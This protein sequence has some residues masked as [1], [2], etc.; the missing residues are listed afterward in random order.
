MR[1]GSDYEGVSQV[2]KARS[3]MR[4]ASKGALIGGITLAMIATS[5]TLLF[6]I[7]SASTGPCGTL[8]SGGATP[9]VYIDCAVPSAATPY[10]TYTDAQQV[11]ISIGP[12][13]VFSPSDAQGGDLEA[14]E[15][16]YTTTAGTPGDPPNADFCDAQTAGSDFPEPVNADGSFDY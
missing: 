13:S 14:I 16:E 3:R 7:A 8:A 4:R 6:G 10:T 9:P 11:N 12:N 15:C 1:S 2:A 5:I